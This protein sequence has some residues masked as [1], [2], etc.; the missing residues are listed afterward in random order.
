MASA[1]MESTLPNTRTTPDG[2]RLSIALRT[3]RKRRGLT[4][5]QVA[6][7]WG[8]TVDGY[9]P[10]ERGERHLRIDQIPRLATALKVSEDELRRELDL[11]SDVDPDALTERRFSSDLESIRREVEALPEH[12]GERVIRN[13][14]TA[15]EIATAAERARDN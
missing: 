2:R 10:W 5:Q 1:I 9:R 7:G 12:L 3:L 14:R 6:D 13:F 8:I 15:L 11:V 4:Q